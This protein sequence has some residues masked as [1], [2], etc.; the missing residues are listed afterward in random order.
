MSSAPLTPAQVLAVLP[1]QEPFRFIDEI[2]ELDEDHIVAI[3]RFRP[4]A[5]FYRG[6]F[7]GN[8]VTPGVILIESMAQAGIVA[9]GIYLLSLEGGGYDPE[10]MMTLFTDVNVDFAGLVKP[11]DRV[12]IE[13]RK[14][15][16]RRRKLRSEAEMKLDDGSV[17]CSGTVSG[18]GVAR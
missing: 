9:L 5:D 1:Q 13:A 18:M 6:H 4:E 16:W 10:K 11:G 8:P 7:P 14:V 3:Y 17:V 12:T 2:R 15:F